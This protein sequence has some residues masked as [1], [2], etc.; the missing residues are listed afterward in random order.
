MGTKQSIGHQIPSL[1]YTNNSNWQPSKTNTQ[2]LTSF[3][4]LTYNIWFENITEA[5]LSHIFSILSSSHADFI[6][7]QEVTPQTLEML[8]SQKFIQQKY[9]LSGNTISRY[10]TVMLSSVPC[11]FYE[12]PFEVSMMDRK[13]IVCSVNE[14]LVVCTAHFESL[15]SAKARVAQME[16][17]FGVIRGFQ[18]CIV[19]GDY[20]F[21]SEDSPEGKCF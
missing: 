4:L 5:R 19:A 11:Q 3:S 7:L 8:K 17:T 21:D 10:G 12:L 1:K 16:Q 14:R 6:C 2:D 15:F 18:N 9:W 13:L 20:N